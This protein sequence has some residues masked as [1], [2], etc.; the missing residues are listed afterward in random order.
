MVMNYWSYI[1]QLLQKVRSLNQQFVRWSK[2]F[3]STPAYKIL[4]I[5][6]WWAVIDIW[7]LIFCSVSSDHAVLMFGHA[8]SSFWRTYLCPPLEL[9]PDSPFRTAKAPPALR[10]VTKVEQRS[11]WASLGQYAWRSPDFRA[12]S[13]FT[14]FV[15]DSLILHPAAFIKNYFRLVLTHHANLTNPESLSR[16]LMSWAN[17]SGW[18]QAHILVRRCARMSKSTDR[19]TPNGRHSRRSKSFLRNSDLIWWPL[20][21][22][23]IRFFQFF[24]LRLLCRR[25][26]TILYFCDY[27]AEIRKQNQLKKS[28]QNRRSYWV[29]HSRMLR[30]NTSSRST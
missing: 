23:G 30:A 7:Q 12:T 5:S 28:S 11:Q 6:Y 20:A 2:G 17:T 15:P 14:K 16:H 27:V 18:D 1:P 8:W 19:T 25:F 9:Q 3:F 10:I 21:S 22:C 29:V 13:A 24:S 4:V 26:E